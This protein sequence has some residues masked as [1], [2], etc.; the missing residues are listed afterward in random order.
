MA[1]KSTKKVTGSSSKSSLK[2]TVKTFKSKA[3]NDTSPKAGV[4]SKKQKPARPADT[5]KVEQHAD[6]QFNLR[7]SEKGRVRVSV[8][9]FSGVEYLDVRHMYKNKDEE[10]LPT[11]KG[12]AVP[13]DLARK[14][15]TRLGKLLK[16]AEKA[17]L[18][19]GADA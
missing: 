6:L 9:V 12:C 15:H 1:I 4:K 3:A 14:L 7:K 2:K 17:G 16:K 8:A 13:L 11:K 19:I 10:W 5:E 18:D